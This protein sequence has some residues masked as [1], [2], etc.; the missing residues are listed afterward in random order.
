MKTSYLIIGTSA[1]ALLAV[2]LAWRSAAP[3]TTTTA[4]LTKDV[5]AP[6]LKISP[7]LPA[8]ISPAGESSPSVSELPDAPSLLG[9]IT[10]SDDGAQLAAARDDFSRSAD[11]QGVRAVISKHEDA[12]TTPAQ[13]ERLLEALRCITNP[14]AV[15]A[16]RL[17]VAG[18]EDVELASAAAIG[19]TKIATAEALIALTDAYRVTSNPVLQAAL[20]EAFRNCDP[21]PEC[22]GL[23][24]HLAG[25]SASDMWSHAASEALTRTPEATINDGTL[26]ALP[27]LSP[28]GK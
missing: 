13:R 8:S 16:L 6:V 4:L 24:S 25:R 5:P 27:T 20:V 28:L 26:A 17:V 22:K 2:T 1:L 9:I 18:T 7:A 21:M 11:A 19:L 10:T 3:D 23:L 14:P 12:A 15:E